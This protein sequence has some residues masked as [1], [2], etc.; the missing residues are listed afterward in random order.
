M[1]AVTL[2]GFVYLVAGRWQNGLV[3]GIAVPLFLMVI[4]LIGLS[5]KALGKGAVPRR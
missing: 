1:L 5:L 4:L 2:S 3:E